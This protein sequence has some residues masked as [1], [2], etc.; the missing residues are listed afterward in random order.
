MEEVAFG[1]DLK[2]VKEEALWGSGEECFKQREQQVQMAWG[3]SRPQVL[4]AQQGERQGG[5][6]RGRQW[7]AERVVPDCAGPCGPQ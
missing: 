7:G 3:R 4:E 2:V 6:R 1:Q 5:L